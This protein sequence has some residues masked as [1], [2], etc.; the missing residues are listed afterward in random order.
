MLLHD[1][2]NETERFTGHQAET[3]G[4]HQRTRQKSCLSGRF[5]LSGRVRI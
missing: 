2:L 4:V 5:L 3:R 1:E